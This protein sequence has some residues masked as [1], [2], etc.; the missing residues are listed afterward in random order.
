MTA[1]IAMLANCGDAEIVLLSD[2][3][4]GVGAR[5]DPAIRPVPAAVEADTPF[6]GS[7]SLICPAEPGGPTVDVVT[8]TSG[9]LLPD[10]G[11]P[12]EAANAVV[13][14][15]TQMRV[16][17]RER[18]M[19]L[20]EIA[21][22][23]NPRTRLADTAFVASH[24]G[25]GIALVGGG[26]YAGEGQVTLSIRRK[27]DRQ[28][29]GQ[30]S[31]DLSGVQPSPRG[32]V[33]ALQGRYVVEDGFAELQG[34][35][36]VKDAAIEFQRLME[37]AWQLRI[38]T[39]WTALLSL[40]S[41]ADYRDRS[42]RRHAA[43]EPAGSPWARAR[44]ALEK[45]GTM[46]QVAEARHE[47]K[48]RVDELDKEQDEARQA[49][50]VKRQ[51]AILEKIRAV[52][53]RPDLEWAED[54]AEEWGVFCE[55]ARQEAHRPSPPTVLTMLDRW[56][57]LDGLVD[58]DRAPLSEQS[59]VGRDPAIEKLDRRLRTTKIPRLAMK[60][61]PFSE[62][63]GQFRKLT[64]LNVLVNWDAIEQDNPEIRRRPITADLTN[65]SANA[66][67]ETI[68]DAAGGGLVGIGYVVEDG[69]IAIDTQERLD[70]RIE[71]RMY[72]IRDLLPRRTDAPSWSR[73]YLDTGGGES[74]GDLFGDAD[75]DVDSSQWRS[76]RPLRQGEHGAWALDAGSA[77]GSDEWMMRITRMAG[78]DSSRLTR[79]ESVGRLRDLVTQLVARDSW[80]PNGIASTNYFGG[81]LLIYQTAENQR[82]VQELLTMLRRARP[83]V[84]EGYRNTGPEALFDRF[85]R[86]R[87]WVAKLLAKARDGK[88]G[89]FSSI[90]VRKV[91]DVQYARINGVW[92]DTRLPAGAMVTPLD[93][94]GEAAAAVISQVT[95][96]D[97]WL[98]LGRL[99]VCYVGDR[100][101]FAVEDGGVTD[102]KDVRIQ[103]LL[104]AIAGKKVAPAD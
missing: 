83:T 51:L 60:G 28:V 6:D 100:Q 15:E 52:R 67:L 95:G 57:V 76:I 70:G 44:A 73:E 23:G 46:K 25:N 97:E 89:A 22:A 54:V 78:E 19:G 3:D 1:A 50:E 96:D 64:G 45:R 8:S 58:S 47:Q 33:E 11:T 56:A 75:E 38:V 79:E 103:R 41:E 66:A 61:V 68:L 80:Y 48:R 69:R 42:L 13:A 55:T 2:G 71:V 29:I 98:E 24:E 35:L 34:R 86:V 7:I 63:V 87:P 85:R 31:L 84:Q 72:D 81:I 94:R 37:L 91:G 39:P 18:A 92:L 90:V 104:A 32:W 26:R 74:D 88:L 93:P 16:R 4:G 101:A 99:V 65:I 43:K 62:A 82:R 59:V 53:C 17:R 30:L 9:V 36:M 10:V 5:M 77:G 14:Y 49:G 27:S 12:A 40:E 20:L 21:A 102:A